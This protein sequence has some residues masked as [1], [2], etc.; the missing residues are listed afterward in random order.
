MAWFWT[1]NENLGASQWG[2]LLD[3]IVDVGVYVAVEVFLV[4]IVTALITWGDGETMGGTSPAFVSLV[5]LAWHGDVWP[6]LEPVCCWR[7][8]RLGDASNA[9]KLGLSSA[10]YQEPN[11][12]PPGYSSLMADVLVSREVSL[13]PVRSFNIREAVASVGLLCSH[14]ETTWIYLP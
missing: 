11:D 13:Q 4:C 8:F 10:F 5:Y 7:V 12:L 9:G 1:I 6:W 2:A 3:A 14:L